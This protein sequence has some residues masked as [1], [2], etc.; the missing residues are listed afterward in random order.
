MLHLANTYLIPLLLCESTRGEREREISIDK[1]ARPARQ[2]IK[3][4]AL[5]GNA[6]YLL[7]VLAYEAFQKLL[8]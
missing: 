1:I 5:P 2:L 8:F 7:H 3:L 6:L 4:M